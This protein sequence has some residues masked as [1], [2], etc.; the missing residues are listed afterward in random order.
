MKFWDSSAL[1][2][3]LL[4]EP[5]SGAMTDLLR[6]DPA[7]TIWWA[8]PVECQSAIHRKHRAR[9]L[10]S[11]VFDDVLVRLDHLVRMADVVAPTG[12]LRDRAGR[13]VSTR[14]L[15]AAD[16]LQL[17]AALDWCNEAP[18]AEAFVCLD[19]RLRGAA[20]A[21]GFTVLPENI[22]SDGG[23]GAGT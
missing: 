16:A 23:G 5:R 8:A 14:A 1:V 15:R 21:E 19:G 11:A 4:P 9:A 13:L 2:P 22:N 12:P 18:R 6:E 7:M 17:A 3:A 20:R 10:A